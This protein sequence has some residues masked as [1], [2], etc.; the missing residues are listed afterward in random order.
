MSFKS[1]MPFRHSSDPTRRGEDPFADFRRQM[2]RLFEDFS[3]GFP[4]LADSPAGG[5]MA[6]KVNVAETEGGLELTA[7]LPGVDE[8]DIDVDF[9]DGVLTLKA[10]HKAEK[11]EKDEAKHYHLVERAYGTYMRRFALP[12]EA[13]EDGIAARFDK[14]VLTVTIPRAA[15]ATRQARKI[16]VK[17]S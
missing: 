7:E 15:E 11:E 14:G 8:K 10:E 4:A 5:L 3:H 1:L 16:E 13:D 12:F 9:S 2:D 17:G 6:P